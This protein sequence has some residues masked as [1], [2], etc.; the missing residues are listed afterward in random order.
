MLHE[1]AE[2]LITNQ[3]S[4]FFYI[5]VVCALQIYSSVNYKYDV[6]ERRKHIVSIELSAN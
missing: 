3:Q 2:F 6:Y 4:L 5:A 1:M